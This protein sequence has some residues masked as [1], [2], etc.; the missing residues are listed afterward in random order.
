MTQL[1][2]PTRRAVDPPILLFVGGPRDGDILHGV[3]GTAPPPEFR[4]PVARPSAWSEELEARSELDVFLR[5]DR[6]VR[7]DTWTGDDPAYRY[8]YTGRGR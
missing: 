5:V 8:R 4:F 6:Y 3:P 1:S 2:F 7:E